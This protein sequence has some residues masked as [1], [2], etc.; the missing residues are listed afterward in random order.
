MRTGWQLRPAPMA[1]RQTLA[2]LDAARALYR[3]DYFDDC[4]F[5]GDS[6]YVEER[7][8]LLRR[9]YVDVLVAL[10]ERYER[11]GDVL[12]AAAC[13]REAL[14]TSGDEL[15]RAEAGLARLGVTV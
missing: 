6:E 14:H 11:R 12:A 3:G 1:R 7:R 2:A 4:P 8:D 15:P 10:A 9:R 5:Y 13:F